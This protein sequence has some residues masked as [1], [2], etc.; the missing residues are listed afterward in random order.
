MRTE[1]ITFLLKICMH[2]CSAEEEKSHI[3]L[4]DCYWESCCKCDLSDPVICSVPLKHAIWILDAHPWKQKTGGKGHHPSF[5]CCLQH[6]SPFWFWRLAV[7][8]WNLKK[9]KKIKTTTKKSP[10]LCFHDNSKVGSSNSTMH[11]IAWIKHVNSR[12]RC[13]EI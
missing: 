12:Q 10:L 7:T 8:Y 4:F 1:V 5:S 3:R 11:D 13:L 9:K 2:T 6:L